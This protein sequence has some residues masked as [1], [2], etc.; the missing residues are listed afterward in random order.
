[1]GAEAVLLVKRILFLL[2][3]LRLLIS[4]GHL[5]ADAV[6][7]F[8]EAVLLFSEAALLIATF[9]TTTI[10]QISLLL[11]LLRLLISPMTAFAINPRATSEQP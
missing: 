4:P 9:L 8:S 1:M 10:T 7:L 6:L 3:L 2:F 11:F 5:G